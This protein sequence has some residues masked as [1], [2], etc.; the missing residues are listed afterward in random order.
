MKCNNNMYQKQ[1][2]NKIKTIDAMKYKNRTIFGVNIQAIYLIH[3]CTVTYI[4]W[5]MVIAC[6]NHQGAVQ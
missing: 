3:K 6:Y 4:V 5:S 1:S 2:G